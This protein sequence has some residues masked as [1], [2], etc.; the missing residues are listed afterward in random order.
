MN[1]DAGSLIASL[2]IGSIGF[3]LLSY[4]KKQSRFPQMVVGLALVVYPYFIPSV[5]VMIGIGVAL[6]SGLFAAVRLGM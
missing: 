5:W 4:G 2:I 6:V 1:F 3:V